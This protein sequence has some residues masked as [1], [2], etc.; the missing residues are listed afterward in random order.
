[1]VL[2]LQGNWSQLCAIFGT[3]CSS[4]VA[5]NAS[6]GRDILIPEGREDLPNVVRAN[7]L[8]CRT[9]WDFVAGEQCFEAVLYMF[10]HVCCRTICLMFVCAA[11]GAS[12]FL[13]NP[14]TSIMFQTKYFLQYVRNMRKVGRRVT[15]SDFALL[16][17][18]LDNLIIE[19]S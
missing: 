5:I 2:I 8:L 17:M 7:R 12:I 19:G 18:R 10:L 6:S 11:V 4:F 14:A 16:Y 13:E 9:D 3:C 1:M 15:H